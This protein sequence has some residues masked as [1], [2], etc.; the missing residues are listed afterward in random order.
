MKLLVLFS[1]FPYP[2]EKGDKLRAFYQLKYLSKNN[3][4]YCIC[5]NDRHL[6]KEE[7]EK[8]SVFC[9]E[10]H[11]IKINW[12]T[13]IFNIIL[14]YFKGLPIQC[15]YF[16]SHQAQRLINKHIERIKPEHLYGQLV[17]VAEY[18]KHSTIKK[19][20]DYQ[21]VLSKGMHRRYEKE[22]TILKF[23][24]F[25][26]YKRLAKYE[27][28]IFDFFDHHTIIT[29]VD[30]DLIPHP[31]Y[32]KIAVIAN[33]VDFDTYHY[34]GQPKQYDLIFSGN[35]SYLP[36]VDAA[37]FLV[38]RLFPELKKTFPDLT[39]VIC[40]ANP[41]LKVKNL[42]SK[43]I[44]VTGWVNSMADY[45]SKSRIFIAPMQLG[46]GLQNKLLEAMSVQLPCVTST[47]AGMP[48]ANVQAGK[49][50]LICNTLTGYV[51]AVSMLLTSPSLYEEISQNGFQF[52]S[53][54]YNWEQTTA[55]LEALF[56][57]SE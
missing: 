57:L 24:Y 52:V 23:F 4:I 38:Q 45:Y 54:N 47:L 7:I 13:K 37:Q 21:D 1:R 11:I 35:M 9:E 32:N 44:I 16:Y 29:G 48:L 31:Q 36:N 41:S 8:V 51:D 33:G 20:I 17:R 49:E 56:E 25:L 19:T 3:K 30:R 42:E 12:W 27:E 39:L 22:P 46:T 6:K 28:Y 40:G 18:I 53:N 10:L 26:E 5:L 43:D 15:G 14:F 55:Q 50:I 34:D 2:L